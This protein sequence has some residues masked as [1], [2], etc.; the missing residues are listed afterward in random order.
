MQGFDEDYNGTPDAAEG[1]APAGAMPDPGKL[2]ALLMQLVEM[3]GIGDASDPG[4]EDEAAL[5]PEALTDSEVEGISNVP[6]AKGMAQP[7]G[8]PA[9]NPLE[10]MRAKMK[11]G[12]PAM[13]PMAR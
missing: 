8:A 13:P 3:L 4:P 6:D 2:K 11:A 5:P 12:K 1:A 9:G 7:L 10:A